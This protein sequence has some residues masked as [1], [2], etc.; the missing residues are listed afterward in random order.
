MQL[1]PGLFLESVLLGRRQNGAG[2]TTYDLRY[3]CGRAAC[4]RLTVVT[5]VS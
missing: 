1:C 5:E 4:G 2:A 3:A